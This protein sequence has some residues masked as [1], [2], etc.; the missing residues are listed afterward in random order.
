MYSDHTMINVSVCLDVTKL[1]R[2]RAGDIL[3][4]FYVTN[5]LSRKLKYGNIRKVFCKGLVA[6]RSKLDYFV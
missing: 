6:F 3:K 2:A 5:R 4:G 1:K